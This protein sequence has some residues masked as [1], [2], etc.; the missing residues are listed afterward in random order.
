LRHSA[1]YRYLRNSIAELGGQIRHGKELRLAIVHKPKTV[2][3]FSTAG[4]GA[5]RVSVA[6]NLGSKETSGRGNSRPT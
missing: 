2:K 4:C 1:I 5:L 6:I 3:I